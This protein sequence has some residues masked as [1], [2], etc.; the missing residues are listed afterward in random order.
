M[1]P[2]PG[3]SSAASPVYV[4]RIPDGHHRPLEALGVI[5]RLHQAGRVFATTDEAIAAARERLHTTGIVPRL[6]G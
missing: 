1:T 3:W 5:A 6:A 2:S 4:S